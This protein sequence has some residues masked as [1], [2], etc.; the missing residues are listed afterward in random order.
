MNK[1]KELSEI[2]YFSLFIKNWLAF[3]S[4]YVSHY[5]GLEKDRDIIEEIKKTEDTRNIFFNK[6]TKIIETNDRDRAI[7]IEALEGL[8]TSLNRETITPE[9]GYDGRLS[10]ENALVEYSNGNANLQKYKNLLKK[11]TSKDKIKL[12]SNVYITNDLDILYKGLIEILYQLRCMLFHG[13]LSP[14]DSNHSVIKYS[15]TIINLLMKNI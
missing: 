8:I 3:N 11:K 7:L 5:S 6:F 15:Y 4:W 1:W 9:N 2:D 12:T 13:H 14:S 10:F